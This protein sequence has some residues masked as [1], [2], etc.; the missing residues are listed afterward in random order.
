MQQIFIE[1]DVLE[2]ILMQYSVEKTYSH[3][4]PLNSIG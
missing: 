2:V 3:S 1:I 4:F